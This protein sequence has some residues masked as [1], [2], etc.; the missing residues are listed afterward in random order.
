[1]SLEKKF[2]YWIR[3]DETEYGTAY[4]K[5]APCKTHEKDVI[6]WQTADKM[7]SKKESALAHILKNNFSLFAKS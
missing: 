6:T 5:L 1:M 3:P 7:F 4:E 2:G